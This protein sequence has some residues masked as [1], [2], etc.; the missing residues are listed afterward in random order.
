M[1]GFIKDL[2]DVPGCPGV[3]LYRSPRVIK[4]CRK[5]EGYGDI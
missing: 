2:L 5:K 4:A 3:A 1:T